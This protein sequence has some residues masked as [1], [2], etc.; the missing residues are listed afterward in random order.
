MKRIPT[1]IGTVALLNL[2]V[3][4]INAQQELTSQQRAIKMTVSGTNVA[5]TIDLQPGTITDELNFAGNG[6]LGRSSIMNY[7]QTRL[8]PNLPALALA[9][10][11]FI[12]QLR[13]AGA[14]SAS[15]TGV[16]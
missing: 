9:E 8:L 5:T 11:G 14:Y 15:R 10:P 13:S 2:G 1:L 4:S 7:M 3:A 12:F 6:T 16:F